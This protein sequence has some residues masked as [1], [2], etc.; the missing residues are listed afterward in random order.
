ME[1]PRQVLLSGGGER[2]T[3]EYTK[4]YIAEQEGGLGEHR[5]YPPPNRIPP[6]PNPLLDLGFGQD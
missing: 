1:A 5:R 3:V 4:K 6:A 2:N